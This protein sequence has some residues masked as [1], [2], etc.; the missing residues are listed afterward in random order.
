MIKNSLEFNDMTGA[1]I[2]I[3]VNVT[4]RNVYNLNK[5]PWSFW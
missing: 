1:I 3:P 5:A 4:Y 2:R